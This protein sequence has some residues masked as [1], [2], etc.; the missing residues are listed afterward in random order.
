MPAGA[1]GKNMENK[2]QWK[3]KKDSFS[4]LLLYF[5]DGNVRTFWSLDWQ[6]RF[7]KDRDRR[8]GLQRLRKIIEQNKAQIKT[9][10]IY[11]AQSGAE[12][13]RSGSEPDRQLV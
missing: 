7:S 12:L 13:E 2:K 6:H 4:K 5:R 1:P 11:D 3:L 8:I 9:A 10:I